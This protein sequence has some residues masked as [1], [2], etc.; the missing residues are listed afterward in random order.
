MKE[1]RKQCSA[2]HLRQI[3]KTVSYVLKWSKK[4]PCSLNRPIC[5]ISRLISTHTYLPSSGPILKQPP[6]LLLRAYSVVYGVPSE[7]DQGILPRMCCGGQDV[8][9]FCFFVFFFI[10]VLVFFFCICIF[11]ETLWR[12]KIKRKRYPWT[13][14]FAGNNLKT[15]LSIFLNNADF[16]SYFLVKGNNPSQNKAAPPCQ[17]GSA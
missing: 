8:I 7:G 15:K 10:V 11:I 4:C 9:V 12:P 17:R 14:H 3:P 2:P 5:L 6:S 1:P 13:K 16:T